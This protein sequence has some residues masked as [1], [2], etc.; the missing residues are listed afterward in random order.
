[1]ERKYSFEKLEVYQDIRLYIKLIYGLTSNFPD[2]ERYGL[3]PQLQRAAI[4]VASNIVEGTTRSTNKEKIRFIEISYSSLMETYCQ[5]QI[6]E[7]LGYIDKEAIDSI[8]PHIAKIA[9]KLSALKRTL[10]Q[11]A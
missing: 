9:N 7:D 2:K 11:N 8:Q 6:S 3:I 4:S 1:M 10:S 5:L